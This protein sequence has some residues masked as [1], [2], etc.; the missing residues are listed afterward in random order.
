MGEHDQLGSADVLSEDYLVAQLKQSLQASIFSGRLRVTPRRVG[1]VAA[2]VAASFLQFRDREQ[3][4]TVYSYGEHLA[5]EGVGH[6]AVLSLAETL[7]RVCAEVGNP[8]AE[9]QLSAG[10]YTFALLEGYMAGR[11]S[12]LLQQQDLTHRA[13]ERARDPKKQ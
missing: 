6:R 5:K 13:L 2:E 4:K 1:E 11:E 12:Y 7:R 8:A 10:R 3:E 9:L